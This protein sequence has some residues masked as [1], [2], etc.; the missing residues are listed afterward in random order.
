MAPRLEPWGATAGPQGKATVLTFPPSSPGSL[1]SP[2]QVLLHPGSLPWAH[3]LS[4]VPQVSHVGQP[5]DQRAELLLLPPV[6]RCPAYPRQPFASSWQW[7][8]SPQPQIQSSEGGAI[9][10]HPAL[11][12]LSAGTGHGGPAEVGPA[13]CRCDC[14]NIFA[15]PSSHFPQAAKHP[16]PP[17]PHRKNMFTDLH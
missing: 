11:G 14:D 6:P 3:A 17:P 5:K 1:K 15:G 2:G 4:H 7:P 9:F 10:P 12:L 8:G 13:L 16:H